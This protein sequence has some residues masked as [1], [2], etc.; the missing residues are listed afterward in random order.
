LLDLETSFLHA[1]A[2]RVQK[3]D[4][5]LDP[6]SGEL[7]REVRLCP[8]LFAQ[9][10][11][12]DSQL[13]HRALLRAG[14][15]AHELE[16]IINALPVNSAVAW[17]VEARN[18]RLLLQKQWHATGI[19]FAG[20]CWSPI[21]DLAMPEAGALRPAH[22]SDVVRLL[23]RMQLGGVAYSVWLALA[24]TTGW[25]DGALGSYGPNV[26]CAYFQ[27]APQG[28]WMM[29]ATSP[30]SGV[31][32]AW[33]ADAVHPED[34]NRLHERALGWFAAEG[35]LQAMSPNGLTVDEV[36]TQTGV[37]VYI[38]RAF[39]ERTTLR[40]AGRWAFEAGPERLI[41]LGP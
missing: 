11:R 4:A 38:A 1:I 35:R 14:Y 7:L 32:V 26:F 34:E 18:A 31:D 23:E 25:E 41:F 8:H 24:S 16:P 17:A 37:P 6:R 5:V 36:V 30:S 2:A 13:A 12:T 22:A 39:L 3:L 19:V 15:T 21:E 33:F 29:R 28:G 10:S 40:E 27:P 20:A 9:H